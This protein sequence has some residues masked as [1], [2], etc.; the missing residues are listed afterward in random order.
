MNKI[1]AIHQPNY[2][3]WLGYFYKIYQS[4]VFV[5]LD[6]VQYS[7]Q[8]MHNYTYIK[9]SNGPHRLKYPV[10]QKFKDK[11]MDVRSKDLLDW[12]KKHLDLISQNY[13]KANFFESVYED[14]KMIVSQEYANIVSLNVAII[15]FFAEKLDLNTQFIISSKLGIDLNRTEKIIEIC[16]ALS[17][18]VYYSGTGA[19]AYQNEDDFRNHGIELKYSIFK[20]FEYPQ[21]WND[22]QSNVSALDF[23]MNCGYDWERVVNNQKN[24]D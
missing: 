19:R 11:I 12:K 16:K 6:D 24:Y 18:N 2:L 20:P 22:F 8:G 17:G 9:T 4:D 1:I 7:N 15:T 13:R 23:F 3:P 5:F 10:H 21:L 14:Y